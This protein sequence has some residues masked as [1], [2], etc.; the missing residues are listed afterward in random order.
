M[1]YFVFAA[2]GRKRA[3]GAQH[4]TG[5][6]QHAAP[7]LPAIQL[8]REH[9]VEV[10]GLV[11]P[12]L[13]FV[14]ILLRRSLGWVDAAVLLALYV[15]YLWALLRTAPRDVDRSEEHTSELQ[16]RNDISYAVFCLKK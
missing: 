12:L 11:P 16:S 7:L 14:V 9:A 13:Y 6:A 3:V 15:A 8:D 4:T 10:V 1:I 5:G 2:A